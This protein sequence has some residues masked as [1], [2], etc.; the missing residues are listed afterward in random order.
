MAILKSDTVEALLGRPLSRTETDNFELYAEIAEQRLN[1]EL[2][3][4]IGDM[5][6]VPAELKLV[7]ARFFG[8]IAAENSSSGAIASK[9]VED[10][11]ITF[12]EGYKPMDEVIAQNASIIAKYRQPVIR[13]GRTI[14]VNDGDYDDRF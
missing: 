9:R 13:H 6:P 5:D 1:G 10:F 12:R 14:R 4:N 7:L 8:V 2:L 3:R 11:Y